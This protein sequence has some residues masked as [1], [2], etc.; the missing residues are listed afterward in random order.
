MRRTRVIENMA[1]VMNE[2]AKAADEVER[3]EPELEKARARLGAKVYEA[4][5]LGV[6]Y[7]SLGQMLGVTRQRAAQ[8]A[9]RASRGGERWTDLCARPSAELN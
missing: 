4:H 2:L 6:T 7:Q 8:L 9:E 3:L 5:K 1:Q